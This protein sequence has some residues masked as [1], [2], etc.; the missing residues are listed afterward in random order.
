MTNDTDTLSLTMSRQ[1]PASPEEVFDAYTDAEKQKI[2]F[3]ILDT[4]PGIVEIDVDLRVGGEQTAK[5]GPSRD[6][7]FVETQVFREIDRPN[8]LVTTSTGSTPDGMT[9]TT[10]IV[11]TFESVD[12]GTLMTVTQSGFPNVEVRDFFTQHAWVGAFDRIE[13]YLNR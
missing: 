5:W 13:A 6:E 7:L 10:E 12:G 8:R 2:W 4:E 1:L 3:G 9:M 11:V